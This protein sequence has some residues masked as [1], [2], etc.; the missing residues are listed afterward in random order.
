METHFSTS[1]GSLLSV[2]MPAPK[3]PH[4]AASFSFWRMATFA[5]SS[6][7]FKAHGTPGE[8]AP[9]TTMSYS[10]V[11]A[12]SVIGS[13]FLKND[14]ISFISLTSPFYKKWNSTIW[15]Y[16]SI[17]IIVFIERSIHGHKIEIVLFLAFQH[18]CFLWNA[19]KRKILF[20]ARKKTA[21]SA[22]FIAGEL[23]HT[24]YE[25]H[26]TGITG[27]FYSPD[28]AGSRIKIRA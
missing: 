15:Y 13:G 25:P 19:G 12:I 7:A 28:P 23:T 24:T 27:L 5:P 1:T 8:P 9:M 20:C 2:R 18:T 22:V 4:A 26:R 10:F 6:A 3:F 17:S 21:E 16:L 14:G 11:S